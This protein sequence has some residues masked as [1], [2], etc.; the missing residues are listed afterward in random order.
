M[1]S[2]W[3]T[4]IAVSLAVAVGGAENTKFCAQDEKQRANKLHEQNTEP[5][6]SCYRAANDD[7]TTLDTSRLCPLPECVTWLN[8][9]RK[10]EC[11]FAFELEREREFCEF[12]YWDRIKQRYQQRSFIDGRRSRP[13]YDELT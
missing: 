4:A 7:I 6:K 1:R 3:I 10:F 8:Y 11:K 9:M 12:E 2:I 5:A 13:E